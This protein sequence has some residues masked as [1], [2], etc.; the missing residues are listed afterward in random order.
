MNGALGKE[1]ENSHSIE[2][3][4]GKSKVFF[5]FAYLQFLFF[6]INIYVLH[7]YFSY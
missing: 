1:W 6:S 3:Q 4:T 2:L 5:L 7:M